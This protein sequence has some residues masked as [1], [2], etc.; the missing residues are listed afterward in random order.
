MGSGEISLLL[1]SGVAVAGA[2]EKD[3]MVKAAGDSGASESD[4]SSKG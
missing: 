4:A 3:G 2:A 1:F